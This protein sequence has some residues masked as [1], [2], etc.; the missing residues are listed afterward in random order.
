MGFAKG[1][2]PKKPVHFLIT[3]FLL[4]SLYLLFFYYH[5]SGEARVQHATALKQISA[6]PV[7]SSKATIHQ[8]GLMGRKVTALA[9]LAE[10]YLNNPSLDP[11]ELS[12]VV[13]EQFP[14]WNG[15]TIPY[16]PWKHKSWH[17]RP[18]AE[19]QLFHSKTGIVICA[20]EV[21]AR[22]AGH[23]IA[24]LRNVHKSK[25]PIDIAYV[26]DEDLTPRVRT[27]LSRL[28]DNVHFVDLTKVFDD[29]LVHLEMYAIKPFALLASRYP[30]TILMDADAVFFSRPD[31]IFQDYPGLRETGALFFHDRTITM[32]NTPERHAWLGAQ[33]EAA[34][35]QPS[36]HL[37]HSSLFYRRYIGEE[38]DAAVVCI[39]KSRPRMYMAMVFA[40]WMNIQEVRDT[41]TWEMWHGE[42]E[43]YWMGCELTGLP[44]SFEPWSSARLAQSQVDGV[45]LTPDASS[46]S[47]QQRPP[48]MRRGAQK[49][50][51]AKHNHSGSK[52]VPAN[53][54]CTKHMVHS[55]GSG[56]E[57][58]WANDGLWLDKQ[59][60]S[61][62]LANWT[63]WLLGE[64][65]DKALS[66]FG[67]ITIDHAES[68]VSEQYEWEERLERQRQQ[69]RI[70]ATQPKWLNNDWPQDAIVCPQHDVKRWK[71][72]DADF[73]LRLEQM[74]AEVR[75]VEVRYKKEVGR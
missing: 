59:D 67:P 61:L 22:E 19:G 66:D 12:E 2:L 39:D 5:T 34:G 3:A 41:V 36:A 42:K 73:R 7:L 16:F 28:A 37:N 45:G 57:P 65:I 8:F 62:G 43:T 11:A 35:R 6:A 40:C 27:F 60:K 25:L 4:Q 18:F 26:G 30:Q 64:R 70:M 55:D 74:I 50:E 51:P 9:D 33:L 31:D 21:N 71:R 63:H 32:E 29:S 58:L 69:E 15:T 38:V 46:E 44:Y 72:L 24:Y 49:R 20:G 10:H 17:E 52:K 53:R 14:W 48:R 56:K 23:L 47:T 13:S 1:L 68:A 75:K 54:R